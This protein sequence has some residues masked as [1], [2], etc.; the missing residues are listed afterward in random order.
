MTDNPNP[1]DLEVGRRL[2]ATRVAQGRT[3]QQLAAAVRLTFQQIQ[4]YERGSNRISASKL[5]EMAE[6]LRCDPAGL[7]PQRAELADGPATQLTPAASRRWVELNRIFQGLDD[8]RQ[9]FL[10][11]MARS[12]GDVS[13]PAGA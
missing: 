11:G 1:I 13:L 4:K 10:L 5:V 9:N 2:R 8:G 3:Q 6:Y 12:V 7:L